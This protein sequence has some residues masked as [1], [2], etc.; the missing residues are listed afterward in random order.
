MMAGQDGKGS[1]ILKILIILLVVALVIVIILPG[2]IWQEEDSVQSASRG[3]MAT[4]YE[5]Y[6]YYHKLTGMYTDDEN[7]IITRIQN[8]S[9]LIKRQAVVNFTTDLKTSMENFL[10][11]PAVNT[12][13]DISFNLKNIQDD[14]DLNKR[15]FKIIPEIDTEAEDVKQQISVLRSGMD[16]VNYN[17]AAVV[18]DSM[19]QLRRDLT[20]YPLQS[21]ARLAYG[22]STEIA[23]SLPLVDFRGMDQ[24]WKPLSRK[25]KQLM[26]DVNT[27]RLK[28]L[29]SVADRVA[30]FQAEIKSGFDYFLSA[31]N[32]KRFEKVT[33][34]SEELS[35]VY[36]K[37]LSDFFITQ[38]F[39][40]YNLS[41]SDSLLINISNESFFT[42][43]QRLRY[44]V[45]Y[46][47]STGLR[48]EDPTLLAEL[49]EKAEPAIENISQLSFMSAFKDYEQ[50]I[51]SLKN[52]YPEVKKR[53]RRNIDIMIQTKEIEGA[54]DKLTTSAAFDAY[55]KEKIF[56]QSVP[57]SDS[58]SEIKDDL[59]SSL[60]GIGTFLQVYQE[61]FFGNLDSVHIEIINQLEAYDALLSNMRRNTFTFQPFIDNLNQALEQIKSVPKTTV[62][63]KLQKIDENLKNLYLFASEGETKKVYGIFSRQIVNQGKIYGK[64]GIK[65]WEE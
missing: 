62:V 45:N 9:A 6:Q 60:L 8:D 25:V 52:Y 20:D 59:E 19:K 63:P 32:D 35:A 53:Y 49:K 65:S 46:N 2:E 18:L 12:L 38:Q 54:L 11:K 16:F 3:N 43:N 30:D 48:V 36:N 42:P 56:V 64:T 57:K 47:D 33:K 37:F 21:A 5:A 10:N 26:Q 4:L 15:F 29:T 39:A 14:L 1:I 13:Y 50:Q 40:Q 51:D 31:N 23:A 27:S 55:E 41:E 22:F 44:I 17:E 34:A 28:N 24:V 7:E 61:N 58:Y